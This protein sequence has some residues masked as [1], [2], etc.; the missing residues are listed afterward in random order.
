MSEEI[1]VSE[2]KVIVPAPCPATA[3]Q[4]KSTTRKKKRRIVFADA[5]ART[6]LRASLHRVGLCRSVSLN[7]HL[8]RGAAIKKRDEA[9]QV[10][11]SEG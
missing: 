1:S 8:V 9:S 3:Q 5:E 6:S 11:I 10:F 4:P 2:A 7:N